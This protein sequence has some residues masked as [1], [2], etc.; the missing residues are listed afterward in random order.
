[1]VKGL[2][3]EDYNSQWAM[4]L[5]PFTILMH[6]ELVSVFTHFVYSGILMRRFL[7]PGEKLL[8]NRVSGKCKI[9]A[10]GLGTLCPPY[11]AV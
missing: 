5:E 2:S 6:G 8:L 3:S 1:M 10:S 11:D 7:Q 9:E 4:H